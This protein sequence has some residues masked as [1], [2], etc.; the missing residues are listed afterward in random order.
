MRYFPLIPGKRVAQP[1]AVSPAALRTSPLALAA[2][3]D[4]PRWVEVLRTGVHKSR[5]AGGKSASG[6]SEATFT[7]ADLE[8]AVRGFQIAQAEDF[9]PMGGA[10]VGYDH[11]EFAAALRM[12]TGQRADEGEVFSAAAQYDDMRV[13]PNADGGYSLMARHNYTEDGRK[14]VRAGA[15]RGYSIDIAPPGVMQRRDG[16]PINEW[17]PFGG[18]LTNTSFVRGM[19]PVAASEKTPAPTSA[20][21]GATAMSDLYTK[22]LGLT[23][24]A[25]EGQQ[26]AALHALKEQAAKV[27]TLEKANDH[28]MRERDEARDKIAALSERDRTLT[29]RQAVHDGRISV[30]DADEGENCLYWEMLH[31]LGEEKANKAFPAGAIAQAPAVPRET[32]DPADRGS[33]PEDAFAKVNA[34]AEKIA[35]DE[36]MDK[37]EAFI[38]AWDLVAPAPTT[39]GAEA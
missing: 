37:D 39:P 30:A 22:I 13:E 26:L 17:V 8:S 14:R 21:T 11:S 33:E 1:Y 35:K 19:A 27:P 23:E 24:G 29:L 20:N 16:T 12:V 34:L 10:P 7:Q 25:T 5:F 15:F 32:V 6:H 28:L 2:P 4:G 31:A 9:F 38:R 18:T 36:G 3:D